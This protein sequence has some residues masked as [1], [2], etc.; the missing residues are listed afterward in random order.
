MEVVH[1]PLRLSFWI[2]EIGYHWVVGRKST[3]ISYFNT[4]LIYSPSAFRTATTFDRFYSDA[5]NGA[6]RTL[7]VGMATDGP[8]TTESCTTACFEDGWRFAG[9]EFSQY[10]CH[11]FHPSETIN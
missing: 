2:S 9:T 1:Q 4:L 11:L 8:V 3:H 10:V 6:P 5:V 7:S